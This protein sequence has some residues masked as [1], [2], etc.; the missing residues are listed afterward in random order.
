MVAFVSRRSQAGMSNTTRL[1]DRAR[2]PMRPLV[3]RDGNGRTVRSLDDVARRRHRR[4]RRRNPTG[5]LQSAAMR[6]T[7][8]LLLLALTAM[9]A[10][11]FA[12][13]SVVAVDRATGR[14]VIAS[15]TCVNGDD[16][17]LKGVQA[18]V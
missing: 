8:I 1:Y 14:V 15:A 9:P 18:V 7:V 2:R 16:D 13:W 3:F 6:R 10:S 11:A 4:R 5:T 12:T 17:F